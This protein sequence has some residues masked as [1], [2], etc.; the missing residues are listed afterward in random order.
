M[1]LDNFNNTI[2]VIETNSLKEIQIML[3]GIMLMPL[4]KVARLIAEQEGIPV[5]SIQFV[6]SKIGEGT[7]FRSKEFQ[8]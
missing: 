3:K 6:K 7:N 4:I 5:N 8:N 2:K 1:E